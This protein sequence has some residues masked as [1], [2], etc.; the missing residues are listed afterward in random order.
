MAEVE[1][2][3]NRRQQRLAIKRQTASLRHLPSDRWRTAPRAGRPA[4]LASP[5]GRLLRRPPG[6][7]PSA[8]GRRAAGA[9]AAGRRRP[10]WP[11][12]EGGVVVTGQ[13][14][15]RD[16][17][18]HA[19]RRA[20]VCPAGTAVF[21]IKHG[22]IQQTANLGEQENVGFRCGM[23]NDDHAYLARSLTVCKRPSSASSSSSLRLNVLPTPDASLTASKAC[24]Q[25]ICSYAIQK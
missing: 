12:R 18:G 17:R 9:G 5:T 8:A 3:R 22:A 15:R 4:P 2:A 7:A 13:R 24:S 25:I 11:A 21:A 16:C 10:R 14:G 6:P 20:V 23:P 19:A 1:A